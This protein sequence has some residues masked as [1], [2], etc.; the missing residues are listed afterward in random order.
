[1]SHR[2]CTKTRVHMKNLVRSE[3]QV[4]DLHVK[5]QVHSQ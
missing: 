5:G 1:M 4:I 3:K 2:E